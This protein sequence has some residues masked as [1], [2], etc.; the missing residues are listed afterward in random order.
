[1]TGRR[2]EVRGAGLSQFAVTVHVRRESASWF[3]WV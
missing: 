1:M 3:S 2:P